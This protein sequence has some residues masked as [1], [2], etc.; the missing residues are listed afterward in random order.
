MVWTNSL[1]RL[2]GLIGFLRLIP[3]LAAMKRYLEERL[4]PRARR[5]ARG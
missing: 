1:A 4:E 3:A 5:V 2:T